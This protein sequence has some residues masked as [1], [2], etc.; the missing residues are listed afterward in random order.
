MTGLG[1]TKLRILERLRQGVA[2]VADLSHE[3]QISRVAIH[4]H[5]E[6]LAHEGLIR[7]R[8]EKCQGRGRPRQVFVAVDEQAPYARLCSEV[9]DHL[10][11]LFGQE[12]ILTV[13]SHRNADLYNALYP[14]LANRPLA[15]RL[16]LL[17]HHLTEEGYQARVVREGEGFVLEQGRCPRL[18]LSSLFGEFCESETQLYQL[19]LEAPVIRENQIAQGSA[20]CRYR[21]GVP[22]A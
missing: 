12:A 19:L 18:A 7:A 14:Q 1:E 21:I 13:L 20:V 4:R 9:L 3:L 22:I 16:E 11:H 15:E 2:S 8:V 17:A 6:D 5:L 10:R